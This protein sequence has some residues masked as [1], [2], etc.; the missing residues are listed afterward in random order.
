[1]PSHLLAM[2]ELKTKPWQVLAIFLL[3]VSRVG[4]N[5]PVP[6]GGL[7]DEVY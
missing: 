1:M 7:H 4:Q 6:K 3:N 2:R 5:K